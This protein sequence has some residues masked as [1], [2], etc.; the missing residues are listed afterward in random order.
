MGTKNRGLAKNAMQ[1]LGMMDPNM[2]AIFLAKGTNPELMK[3]AKQVVQSL[4]V[5]PK[6]KMRMRMR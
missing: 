3:L 2:V 1:Q 6:Q 5:V 4:G